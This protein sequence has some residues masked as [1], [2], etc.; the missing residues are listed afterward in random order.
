MRRGAGCILSGDGPMTTIIE[1]RPSHENNKLPE[2]TRLR[3]LRSTALKNARVVRDLGIVKS[4]VHTVLETLIL[5][6]Q[7]CRS[8]ALVNTQE[9]E[10][11]CELHG[12]DRTTMWRSICVLS[13]RGLVRNR[14]PRNGARYT[15]Q[16]VLNGIDLTPLL[17]CSADLEAA[18][19]ARLAEA[20]QKSKSRAELR[21]LKG[22]LRRLAER[23][24]SEGLVEAAL[25]CLMTIPE[26]L[27]KLSLEVMQALIALAKECITQ[28]QS[29]A[30]LSRRAELQ[31]G[32]CGVDE[33]THTNKKKEI[34]K[35]AG[36]DARE[37]NVAPDYR[38]A[39]ADFAVTVEEA[40]M[41]LPKDLRRDIDEMYRDRPELMWREIYGYA[42][43]KWSE[44]GSG[45]GV[46]DQIARLLGER[47]AAVMMLLALTSAKDGHVR[48][49]A[50][51]AFGC[52]R[53]ATTGAFMWGRGLRSA[54]RAVHA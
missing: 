19:A 20:M 40:L 47:Q 27:S 16:G 33:H 30:N 24:Q 4:R 37:E 10:L 1:D 14:T 54:V 11:L 45:G 17:D 38:P 29:L 36:E 8:G 35:V 6:A 21:G 34:C 3:E 53:R 7:C 41:L 9:V 2:R 31:H 39:E 50:R 42:A 26:R 23:N 13:D 22:E 52:A 15:T 44:T 46:P 48:D 12:C 5:G 25:K 43:W 49:L 28:A 51:Y 32:R 18:Q